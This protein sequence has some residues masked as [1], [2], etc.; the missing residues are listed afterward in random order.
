MSLY[1]AK[2]VS[3]SLKID[4]DGEE[5]A[6]TD[7]LITTKEGCLG[8]SVYELNWNRNEPWCFAGVSFNASAYFDT[9]PENEKLKIIL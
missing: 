2:S 8:D 1:M 9:V 6:Q 4:M 5:N 3:S 7:Y